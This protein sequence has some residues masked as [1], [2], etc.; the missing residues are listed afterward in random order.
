PLDRRDV[1]WKEYLEEQNWEQAFF[2]GKF[3][4]S[5]V[6]DNQPLVDSALKANPDVTA[7]LAPYDEL[8]KATVSALE[9]NDLTDDIPVYGVDISNADIE[10]MPQ[11][12][13]PWTATATKH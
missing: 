12:G 3:T 4:D 6:S 9:D 1:V 5:I 11:E 2:T 10:V 8:T 13:R 7:I